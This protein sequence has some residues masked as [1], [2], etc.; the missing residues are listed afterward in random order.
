VRDSL[1]FGIRRSD[2]KCIDFV[3][4]ERQGMLLKNTFFCIN[5][6]AKRSYCRND[7]VQP[8]I[9]LSFGGPEYDDVV[10]V[11]GYTFVLMPHVSH[12]ALK[13]LR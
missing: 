11:I 1:N 6:K 7:V 8:V 2:L 13:Y 3:F 9:V 10:H 5:L 4:Q 12:Q